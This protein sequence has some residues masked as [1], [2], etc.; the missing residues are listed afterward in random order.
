MNVYQRVSSR[1][2]I[3]FKNRIRISNTACCGGK[4][5]KDGPLGDTLDV[6]LGEGG[7]GVPA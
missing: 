7:L 4:Y 2:I 6:Y 3:T 1:S 5:E